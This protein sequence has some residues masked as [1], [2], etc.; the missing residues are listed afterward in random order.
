MFFQQQNQQ[1]TF[2]SSLQTSDEEY[3]LQPD[4]YLLRYLKECPEAEKELEKKLA[5]MS[6][7]TDLNL[8]EDKVLV[9]RSAQPGA[10]DGSWKS[11]VDKLFDG[12]LCHYEL[13]PHKI[14]ALLKSCGLHQTAD[15]VK[16]Y[17]DTGVAI[18]VGE[19]CQVNKR[20]TE[21]E[22]SNVKHRRSSSSESQTTAHRLGK[23]K[24]RLLWK[25]IEHSLRQSFPGLKVTM[26]D[27]GQ[28]FLT[29]SV[30]EI[31]KAGKLI[32]DKENLV[33]ERT[34]SDKSP[35]FL[36]FL[37]EV[38]GGPGMLGGYLGVE[39]KVEVELR[40]TELH[41]FSLCA[42]KLDDSERK[43]QQKF[44]DV[45]VDVPNCPV[46]PPELCEKLKA[47]S[48]EMNQKECRAQVA[49]GPKSIVRLVGHTKDVEELNDVLTQF[50]LDQSVIEG[51]VI[52]PFQELARSLPELLKL[53]KLDFPGV[54]FCP[55]A[56]STPMVA[57]EGPSCKVT[58]VRNRLGPFL[59]SL[60]RNRI[61]IDLPG[62]TRYF[63]S[64]PGRDSLLRVA[65]SHKCLIHL[66]EQTL[67]RRNLGVVKYSLQ[68]GLQVLVCQGDITKQYADALVNAANE[69]LDHGGG[70]A[71]ALSKAG[72][73]EVQKESKEIVKQTGKLSTGQVVVT[74]GGNLK[75]KKLLHAVGPIGGQSGGRER[76][77]LEATTQ[78][79]LNLAEMME[80]KSIAIPCISSGLFGVP[81]AVCSE[82]IVTAVKEFASPGGR[83]LSRIILI[84]NRGEVVRA[85]Q[86]AC[87]RLLQGIGTRE[88][89]SMVPEFQEA[90][91]EAAAAAAVGGGVKVE[92]VQG[93][94]ETQQV[95]KALGTF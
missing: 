62:A 14:K 87:D 11:D 88:S 1:S 60:V 38:Y 94:I 18:V 90:T 3:E 32:S 13:D 67:I 4:P 79:A 16:L 76:S 71:A 69:R 75:C 50:I 22:D 17:S 95:R 29:G 73:P 77:L 19:R 15:G 47:K 48:K 80:L 31:L 24:L 39:D 83:S 68:D 9:Q 85:I 28:V 25:D 37:R 52:L 34:V 55:V 7:S 64:V 33:L 74:T 23:A 57:L 56:S 66:E 91:R 44:K 61:T 78:N 40:D 21:I 84:D 92:V 30:E 65:H 45:K 54:N 81:V 8:H 53:H 86:E 10:G 70:V 12:Y 82:A 58:E 41:F 59:D 36:A 5:L 42:A 49:F 63:E 26:G 93:T 35:H 72:G 89:P 46:V 27:A 20:L 2:G 43:M 51:T 6:C